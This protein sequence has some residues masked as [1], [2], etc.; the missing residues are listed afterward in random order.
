MNEG[1]SS[2]GRPYQLTP[3]NSVARILSSFNNHPPPCH[4]NRK[5]TAPGCFHLDGRPGLQ[6]ASPPNTVPEKQPDPGTSSSETHPA[7]PA[8]WRD[9]RLH[10]HPRHLRHLRHPQTKRENILF[11]LISTPRLDAPSKK[12]VDQTMTGPSPPPLSPSLS[13]PAAASSQPTE[14][15][16]VSHPTSRPSA[17]NLQIPP[18]A[19]ASTSPTNS[20]RSSPAS[21]N[22]S[23]RA[24]T[25]RASSVTDAT[26]PGSWKEQGQT[27][28]ARVL[29]R[30]SSTMLRRQRS[31]ATQLFSMALPCPCPSPSAT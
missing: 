30:Q 5:T 21:L 13:V 8:V 9:D 1:L 25:P 12:S 22:S 6:T 26:T 11:M 19:P 24:T 23:T 28:R 18:A 3:L 17:P 15:S 31:F 7:G 4:P 2:S 14:T 16:Y 20:P 10:R 29:A 27:A